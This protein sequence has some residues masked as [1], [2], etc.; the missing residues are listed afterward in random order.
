MDVRIYDPFY[1]PRKPPEQDFSM[2]VLSEVLEHLSDP[3]EEFRRL[4]E[5]TKDGARIIL[6]TAFVRDLSAGWFKSWW[7]KEDPTHIR[8]YNP[9]SLAELGR[10]SGWSLMYQDDRSL[11]VYKK[12]AALL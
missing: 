12:T 4:G 5:I 10:R 8:F 2:V 9:S 1:A 7:Y 6:K 3:A 11:A